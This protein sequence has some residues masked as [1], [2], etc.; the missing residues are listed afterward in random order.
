MLQ[1]FSE[2]IKQA[3][4]A[5]PKGA[6]TAE[7]IQVGLI[8]KFRL[9]SGYIVTAYPQ[10]I[11]IFTAVLSSLKSLVEAKAKLGSE[12]VKKAAAE[13]IMGELNTLYNMLCTSC[14]SCMVRT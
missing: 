6:S 1:H 8:F 4:G 11:N 2:H 9:A 12:E 3:Q 10:Q 5:K 14:Q 13:L 7:A